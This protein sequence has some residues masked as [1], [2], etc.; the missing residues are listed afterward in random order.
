MALHFFLQLSE[1]LTL[2]FVLT[3]PTYQVLSWNAHFF[4]QGITA[5][6][7]MAQTHPTP[8]WT[9]ETPPP[10]WAESSSSDSRKYSEQISPTI[11]LCLQRAAPSVSKN[12]GHLDQ[13]G[14]YMS[15]TMRNFS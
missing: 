7:T 12:R 3:P 13:V 11:T 8:T 15:Y 4:S 5:P 14:R 2:E 6:L 9:T 1:T 10:P